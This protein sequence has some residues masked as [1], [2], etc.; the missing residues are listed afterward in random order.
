MDNYQFGYVLEERLQSMALND[1]TELRAILKL[2][3]DWERDEH[4]SYLKKSEMATRES[5]KRK[6]EV[7]SVIDN[8]V[9]QLVYDGLG[10]MI[11]KNQLFS[12]RIEKVESYQLKGKDE[13]FWNATVVEKNT[14]LSVRG[15]FYSENELKSISMLQVTF[16][17]KYC[18]D[19]AKLRSEAWKWMR[20]I[21][22]EILENIQIQEIPFSPGW[23]RKGNEWIFWT[24]AN[25]PLLLDNYINRFTV[26]KFSGITAEDAVGSLLDYVEGMNGIEFAGVFL[27]YR[28]FALL[29][30][31]MGDAGVCAGITLIGDNAEKFAGMLLRTMDND[32]DTLN[33]GTDRIGKMYDKIAMLQDTPVMCIVPNPDTKTVQNQ[34]GKILNCMQAG[35]IEGKRVSILFVFVLRHFSKFFPL[36]ETVVIDTAKM[37][38]GEDTSS[39]LKF[40]YVFISI[41]ETSG[42]Y[43]V[44]KLREMYKFYV[45]NNEDKVMAK[46]MAINEITLKIFDADRIGEQKFMKLKRVLH[47]GENEIKH[48]LYLKTGILTEVFCS[49]I[50]ELVD[51]GHVSVIK[52]EDVPANHNE[53]I[54]YYDEECYYFVK[55]VLMKICDKTGIDS[56]SILSIKQQLISQNYVKIWHTGSSH[57]DLEIDFSVHTSCGQKKTLSGFAIL[58]SF[59][60]K[61]GGVSLYERGI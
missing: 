17:G 44:D 7:I 31:L 36:D 60:D 18:T 14:G 43:W 9:V 48:Q 33:L 2:R 54:I 27:D 20:K 38:I 47:E 34:V 15:P 55:E 23:Y 10:Q 50:K 6:F 3:R 24:A 32:V 11:M 61:V 16:L 29:G 53:M 58:K 1:P 42:T 35:C 5:Q 21:L 45:D 52:K 57:R 56:K 13:R 28:L 4:K 46:I 51:A 25:D 41:L 19:D 59:F 30:R 40:Q 12:C 37:R 49:R 22:I 26:E 8:A 39:F